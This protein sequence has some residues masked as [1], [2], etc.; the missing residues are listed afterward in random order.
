M[1]KFINRGFYLIAAVLVLAACKKQLSQDESIQANQTIAALLQDKSRTFMA[2]PE[3]AGQFGLTEN[4]GGTGARGN[5]DDDDDEGD[6]DDYPQLRFTYLTYAL[7]RTGLIEDLAAQGS[8]TVFAPTDDAFRRAGFKKLSDLNAVPVPT[9]RAIL[10]YHVLGAR[11]LAAQVPAGPNAEVTT[12]NGAKVYA[13]RKPGPR[14]FI[15]GEPVIL[16]NIL[17]SNGVLHAIN[18]VLMPPVGNLVQTVV[19]DPDL[20]YLVAAVLRASQGSVNVAQVLSGAG[21]FTVFAPT[22]DA[23]K[24]AGFPTIASITGAN[25]E[26][27]I[28]VLTY[29]VTTGRVFSSDLRNGLMPVMLSGGTT[30][31][32]LNDGKAR[33]RGNGNNQ[34]SKITRT[35]TVATNGVVHVIDRVLLP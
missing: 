6:D 2:N 21:P 19:A 5:D 23:F 34:A 24:K 4:N 9:L 17:A 1:L 3:L 18:K 12:L 7:I 11:V 35:N 14:V 30:T 8:F 32:T 26:Q 15:N 13:T 20:S 10:L 16:P 31:I 25:P 27:L 29:H 28:P 22:N 33:I